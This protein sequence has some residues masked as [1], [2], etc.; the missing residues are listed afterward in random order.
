[1]NEQDIRAAIQRVREVLGPSPG[2]V[3]MPLAVGAALG[4]AAC[5]NPFSHSVAVY[6]DDDDFIFTTTTHSTSSSSTSSTSG[7]ECHADLTQATGATPECNACVQ[8]SC[9]TQAEAF[10]ADPG[11]ATFGALADCALTYPAPCTAPCW[12]T[13]CGDQLSYVFYQACAAC[14]DQHCCSEISACANDATCLNSCLVDA[15]AACCQAGSLY[16]PYD[17]CLV[18]SCSYVCPAA[19]TCPE[20]HQGPGG[21]GGSGGAAGSGGDGGGAGGAGGS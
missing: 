14:V 2:V 11:S 4:L 7:P 13:A 3:F 10:E 1:M 18:A 9:C 8:D 21:A 12:Y 16:K 5:P 6:S 15:D 20:S 17:D 19:F